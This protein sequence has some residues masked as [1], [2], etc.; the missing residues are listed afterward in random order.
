MADNYGVWIYA[1]YLFLLTIWWSFRWEN[2]T[3]CPYNPLEEVFEGNYNLLYAL[4]LILSQ[5]LG[6]L[7]IFRYV[8][9]LWSLEL[10]ETHKGRAHEECVADLQ[11]PM[12][13][14]AIIECIST[15]ICR[16][17]SRA[18][19]ET[20]ARFGTVIDAFFGT[21]MVVAGKAVHHFYSVPGLSLQ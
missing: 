21:L 17:M 14:G 15:C 10:V 3:A 13:V 12:T 7:A 11:V 1:L 19:A 9:L 20:D 18:I 8:Q 5:V 6:G 4:L 16:I 2:A